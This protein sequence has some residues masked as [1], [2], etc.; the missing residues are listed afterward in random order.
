MTNNLKTLVTISPLLIAFATIL[1]FIKL[2]IYY[3]LFNVNI[4]EYIDLSEILLYFFN[5]FWYI[6]IIIFGI[7]IYYLI[8]YCVTSFILWI[9]KKPKINF[10]TDDFLSSQNI[11]TPTLIVLGIIT[12]VPCIF[13][14]YSPSL[15]LLVPLCLYLSQ[16]L[17]L[18]MH[19]IRDDYRLIFS[20]IIVAISLS[21]CLG[22]Y[23]YHQMVF[24]KKQ[25]K[26]TL[27]DQS[28]AV[29][30]KN[31]RVIGKTRNYIFVLND[32]N[33]NIKVIKIESIKEFEYN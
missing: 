9:F 11:K 23:D 28:Q 25:F 32:L 29:E 2:D 21:I 10:N 14:I 15:I 4:A 19:K 33:L 8:V 18:L 6:L 27:N 7:V 26:Y 22:W 5:D 13:F 17:L 12:L 20:T 16:L 24:S 31:E 1:G 30:L 3:S